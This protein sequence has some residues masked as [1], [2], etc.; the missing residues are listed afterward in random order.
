MT[1]IPIASQKIR[2][3]VLG[4]GFCLTAAGCGCSNQP[5]PLPKSRG[6]INP[7]AK[8][9]PPA[10][11]YIGSAAC[12]ECH[13]EIHDKYQT[14]S[15]AR[16]LASVLDNEALALEDRVEISPPGSRRYLVEKRDDAVFHHERFLDQEGETVYDQAVPMD[17]VIGSGRRGQS[18]LINRDGLFFMSPLTWYAQ[19]NQWDLSPGYEPSDHPRFGRRLSEGCIA[20]HAGRPNRQRDASHRFHAETPFFEKAIGCERCHGPGEGH[21]A[22]YAP[23]N[24]Q[25]PKPTSDP[26]V[27]PRDLSPELQNAVCYQC[28]LQGSARI[29]RYGRGDLDFR[30]GEPLESTWVTF[31]PDTRNEHL[32]HAEAVSQVEQM[33]ESTCS[34][35]SNGRMTCTSCHDP[36]GLPRPE[37][38]TAFYRER[39]LKCHN[40]T[41]A[42]C[43]LE[44]GTRIARAD[45]SCIACHMP[46]LKANDVPHTSQ[47]DHRILRNPEEH[48]IVSNPSRSSS[49]IIFPHAVGPIPEVEQQRAWGLLLAGQAERQQDPQKAAAALERLAPL[50]EVFPQDADL[51]DAVGNSHYVRGK[52]DQAVK[53]WQQALTVDPTRQSTIEA[54]LIAAHAEQR[55]ES[56]IQWAEAFLELNSWQSDIYG[57]KAHVL[58][59]QGKMDAAIEAAKQGLELHPGSLPLHGWLAEVY[60]LRGQDDLH[61]HHAQLLKRLSSPKK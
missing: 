27:N 56:A 6:S 29:L 42:E 33:L 4:L 61:R 51:M 26:I 58:G 36:H 1:S 12:A 24:L 32:G 5:P 41:D 11:N 40:S 15:M 31:V 19:E 48:R 49:L 37:S 34:Q 25:S 54:L 45:N 8:P 43:G 22:Y 50:L 52:S 23:L 60:K 35:Q 14:H 3:L 20:C 44:M 10:E 46:A 2:L 53:F 21:R 18:Y 30:P 28:H 55:Y 39:C 57:R 47:T 9:A 16:S 13:Q 59:Q 7:V 17:F 38:R